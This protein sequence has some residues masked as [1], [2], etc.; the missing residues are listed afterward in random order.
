M[1]AAGWHYNSEKIS[2]EVRMRLAAFEADYSLLME[3]ES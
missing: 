1:G 2:F 3:S